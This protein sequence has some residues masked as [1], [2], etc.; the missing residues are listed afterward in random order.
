MG[1]FGVHCD[2]TVL[3]VE[4]WAQFFAPVSWNNL[5]I[6]GIRLDQSHYSENSVE[7]LSSWPCFV[8][9]NLESETPSAPLEPL[10]TIIIHERILGGGSC[11]RWVGVWVV[12]E[13]W[14]QSD[15]TSPPHLLHTAHQPL[16]PFQ[17]LH[18]SH[19]TQSSQSIVVLMMMVMWVVLM[20]PSVG[21][22]CDEEVVVAA[23]FLHLRVCGGSISLIT[24]I[25]V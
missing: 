8:S 15:G 2:G 9:R 18:Q 24:A 3:S 6:W 5:C 12:F 19:C 4:F 20:V 1:H 7:H 17:T 22:Y 23:Y 21:W 16:L 13:G 10:S 25:S 11:G 14:C